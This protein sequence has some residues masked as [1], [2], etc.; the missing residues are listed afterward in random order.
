M[1]NPQRQSERVVIFV[2]YF[3]FAVAVVFVGVF[4][5]NFVFDLD[6]WVCLLFWLNEE[7]VYV[8]LLSTTVTDQLNR[9]ERRSAKKS[10][11]KSKAD[12]S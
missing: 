6:F 3:F 7:N 10:N 8:R 4:F 2:C 1:S 9:I 11:A 12:P 5:L